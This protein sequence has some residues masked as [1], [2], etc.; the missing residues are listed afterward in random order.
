[1]SQDSLKADSI[2]HRFFSK[3]AQLVYHARATAAA[4]NTPMK[5]DRWFNLENPDPEL[6]KESTRPYRSLSSLSVPPPAFIIQVLLAVPEL[7]HNQV[8]VHLPPGGPRTRLDPPPAHVLLEEWTLSISSTNSTASVD[9]NGTPSPS[10]LYKNGIQLFRSVYTLLRVLPA[11]R[12]ARARRRRFVLLLRVTG[13]PPLGDGFLGFDTPPSLPTLERSF[14]PIAHPFAPLELSLSVRALCEPA[15]AIEEME[16]WVSGVLG[17]GA[18]PRPRVLSPGAI[19]EE[20]EHEGGVH[21]EPAR[22]R[23]QREI[24]FMPTLARQSQRSAASSVADRFVVPPTHTRTVSLGGPS[25]LRD[26]RVRDDGG[27]LSTLAARLRRESLSD[28]PSLPS[29]A[30]LP[31]SLPRRSPISGSPLPHPVI[32]PFRSSTVSVGAGSISASPKH[33]PLGAGL[34]SV[35]SSA[36]AT[37]SGRPS[38][39]SPT[40][41]RSGQAPTSVPGGTLASARRSS[42]SLPPIVPVTPLQSI[43]AVSPV[44]PYR[45]SPPSGSGLSESPRLGGRRYM[46][47]FGHRYERG[48]TSASPGSASGAGREKEGDAITP[49]GNREGDKESP[50]IGNASFLSAATDDD[51]ISAFVQDIDARRPLARARALT[52]P[53]GQPLSASLSPLSISPAQLASMSAAPSSSPSPLPALARLQ[54]DSPSRLP[55]SIHAQDAA[56]SSPAS[57]SRAEAVSHSRGHS[58]GSGSPSSANPEPPALHTRTLSLP[59]ASPEPI[60]ATADAVDARLREMNATFLASLQGLGGRRRRVGTGETV[61]SRNTAS[62][63]AGESSVSPARTADPITISPRHARRSSGV[64][65]LA[66]RAAPPYGYVRPRLASTGSARSGASIA[67]EEVLGRMDP[68]LSGERER[69]RRF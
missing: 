21:N 22:E 60:L 43:G 41:S 37:A 31:S 35:P 5:L 8:L 19:R 36:N 20:S 33:S 66:V 53:P 18:G 14:P 3:L 38:M 12:M 7:A 46:S 44:L 63:A 42:S 17:A 54:A 10:T 2:A 13:D 40:S 51:D 28:T 1:M 65:A 32:N 34:P 39:G 56:Q 9:E 55:L 64:D 29:L 26:D 67:S 48:A 16:S 15:F 62:P 30:S 59:T 49:G 27:G 24:E 23:G 57:G 11:W 52:Q 68:E 25:S 4:S 50:R 58:R 47:S 61:T 69:D 45:P 6:Y